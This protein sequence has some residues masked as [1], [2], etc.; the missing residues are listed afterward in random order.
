[1]L[2]R[3]NVFLVGPMGAGKTTVG[4]LLGELLRQDFFDSDAEIEKATGADIPWI[5]D[6]E[7]E[8]GFRKRERKM[9]DFLTSKEN[10]VLATGGGSVTAEESRRMLRERGDVVY[11]RASIDQQIRRMSG[12]NS[13][14]LLQ[15]E[16]RETKIRQLFAIRDPLYKEVSDISIETNGRNA[17]FIAKE[18]HRQL[19]KISR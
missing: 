14:P 2:D 15:V 7:G 4:R 5:F 12:D 11:L 19:N 10:I 3:N 13:R 18:I 9:I 6:V 8:A 16:D 1:M 17:R